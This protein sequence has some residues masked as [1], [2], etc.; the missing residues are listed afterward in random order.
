M[1]IDLQSSI[2]SISLIQLPASYTNGTTINYHA[3]PITIG[4]Q[5]TVH[6]GTS[7]VHGGTSTVHGGT[8]TA[9][10]GT[11]TAHGGTSTAHGGTST[12][13]GGTSTTH[14]GT[15]TAHGGT[16]NT[17]GGTSTARSG[18]T[19][20]N[21][22]NVHVNSTLNINS[23]GGDF[24]SNY[25]SKNNRMDERVVQI[26]ETKPPVNKPNIVTQNGLKFKECG[27]NG[28]KALNPVK[29]NMFSCS[30]I[31]CGRNYIKK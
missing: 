24:P 30:D 1:A 7:T 12:A 16:S 2:E 9:H 19:N 31:K 6:G 17:H 4:G 14:G 18:D 23:Y 3:A 20:I 13:H 15:S 27:Y 5:S 29:N 8:P 21:D 25:H 10:G 22:P 26:T 11:S 28:C